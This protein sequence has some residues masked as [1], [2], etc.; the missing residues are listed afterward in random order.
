MQNVN[1]K[2]KNLSKSLPLPAYQTAQSAGMDVM[3][4][5]DCIDNEGHAYVKGYDW[6]SRESVDYPVEVDSFVEINPGERV[7]ISTGLQVELPEE[8]EIQV[9]PRSGLAL[10]HGITVLNTPGTI[11][12]DYRGIIG[13]I[14]INHS[15]ESF[16]IK[17]GDRIAQIVIKEVPRINWVPTDDLSKTQR[18]EGGFGSTS[19]KVNEP[20]EERVIQSAVDK[21][22]GR[23]PSFQVGDHLDGVGKIA[24]VKLDPG[25]GNFIYLVEVDG[26]KFEMSED[27]ILQIIL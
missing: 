3:A 23:T 17:H 9:R 20:E 16:T 12:A 7:M 6:F 14:L 4:C 27:E 2:V 26:D 18:G 10:K 19:E 24:N 5:F 22:E 25:T 15:N 11:D 1:V 8:Y 21:A 13:I